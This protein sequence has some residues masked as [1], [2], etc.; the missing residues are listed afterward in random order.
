MVYVAMNRY[1]PT[2]LSKPQEAALF[3]FERRAKFWI[4]LDEA[5]EGTA[6]I[7]GAALTERLSVWQYCPEGT[8]WPVGDPPNSGSWQ[9]IDR[10]YWEYERATN[11][12]VFRYFGGALSASL[13]RV[14]ADGRPS[15]NLPLWVFP[16]GTKPDHTDDGRTPPSAFKLATDA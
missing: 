4:D 6:A 13:P 14:D 8:T 11:R 2:D 3:A 10:K 16:D 9:Q 5:V 12:I 7:P 1:D 15:A